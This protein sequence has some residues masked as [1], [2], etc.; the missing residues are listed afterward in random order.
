[1]ASVMCTRQPFITHYLSYIRSFSFAFR[2]LLLMLFSL[3]TDM[4]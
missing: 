4:F 2:Q 1:M 3:K